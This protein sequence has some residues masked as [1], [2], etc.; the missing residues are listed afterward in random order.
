M[1]KRIT[2][3]FFIFFF[4]LAA[5]LYASQQN[6]APEQ[7]TAP[8][9]DQQISDFSLVG[10]GEKGKKSWDIS[11]KSADIFTDLVKLK[12]VVG[13][14]YGEQEDIRLTADRGDFDK[15]E[16]R[17]HL[18]QNV[19]IKTSSGGRLTTNSL[20]WDRK[21]QLVSTKDSVNLEK[22]NM[23]T[24]AQGAIAKPDLNQ[25]T[26]EKDVS[27][28]IVT[29]P[30]KDSDAQAK[31]RIVITCDGPL[32]IDY[33][34]N[35]ATF[36]NNVQVDKQDLQILSDAMDVYFIRQD[37]NTAVL[38][39]EPALMGSRIDKIVARGNVKIIRGENV[40]YSDEAVYNAV[41]KKIILSGRPRLVIYSTQEFKNNAS[42]GN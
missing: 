16:G 31:E 20:D 17:V 29:D 14:L 25:I 39:N 24:T 40:S 22:E 36:K 34:R 21:K 27:V 9:S 33:A 32:E 26:L 41:D 15:N 1:F 37:K 12:D 19:V 11:G 18:E 4:S 23:V 28:N 8:E 10:Y 7:N 3:S 35:L 6:I 2:P 30:S 5:L 38:D 42:T 13:N